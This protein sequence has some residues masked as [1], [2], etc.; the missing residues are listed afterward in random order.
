MI[1]LAYL[2]LLCFGLLDN[3]RGPEYSEILSD[4]HLSHTEG[5]LFFALTSGVC[6]VATLFVPRCVARWGSKHT[7]VVGLLFLG[8]M[9]FLESFS[10]SL[11]QLLM[12]ASLFGVGVGFVSVTQN[13]LIIEAAPVLK[14]RKLLSGLHSMY[15]L[16]ALTAPLVAEW[17]STQGWTWRVAFRAVSVLPIL[18][19]VGASWGLRS[20][21]PRK[22][23]NLI[24]PVFGL[25]ARQWLV[26]IIIAS[27]QIAEIA[28]STRLTIYL[29]QEAHWSLSDARNGLFIFFVL[30]FAGRFL[31]AFHSGAKAQGVLLASAV[32]TLLAF[33]V[34]LTF[35]PYCLVLCGFLL[36]PFF[37]LVIEWI[38][39][40]FHDQKESTISQG[41][42]WGALGIVTMH[43]VVGILADR[44]SLRTALFIGPL[45]LAVTV[46]GLLALMVSKK[47]EV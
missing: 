30:L 47:E 41:I 23:A 24:P 19:A 9:Y 34:G 5:S 17:F 20:S 44:F 31:T 35:S 46:L 14:H 45:S 15:A 11:I 42:A 4:L 7:L 21:L 22:P 38:G 16:S 28:L 8:V 2:S 13:I 6:F 40:L 43:F 1:A 26:V 32:S 18:L 25:R 37:P 29:E 33:A 27:Y 3:L 10:Q 39:Q 12:G 36:A